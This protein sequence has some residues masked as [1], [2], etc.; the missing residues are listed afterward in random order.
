MTIREVTK[1]ELRTPQNLMKLLTDDN[2]EASSIENLPNNEDSLTII[3]YDIQ[4]VAELQLW[5]Y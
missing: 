2:Y 4:T 3:K 1:P 5:Q